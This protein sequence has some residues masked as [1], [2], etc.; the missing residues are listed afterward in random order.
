MSA[1][2]TQP[3]DRRLRGSYDRA[4]A[5]YDELRYI[6]AE[7][8]F[9]SDLELR[10]LRSWLPLAPGNTI[11]DMPAGTGRLSIAL[12]QNGATVVGA[13]ISRNMLVEADGKARSEQATHAHFTQASGVQLPFADNTFDAVACFKFFHLV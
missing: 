1:A 4:A 12:S 13:D 10:V 2:T 8:R 11:L 7:G 6:S 3:D 5:N 9:F